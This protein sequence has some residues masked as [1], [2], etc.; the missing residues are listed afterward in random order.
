[1][2]ALDAHQPQARLPGA[3][4]R[5]EEPLLDR[6]R[7]RLAARRHYRALGGREDADVDL[8]AHRPAIRASRASFAAQGVQRVKEGPTSAPQSQRFAGRSIRG[9][10]VRVSGRPLPLSNRKRVQQPRQLRTEPVLRSPVS[11]PVL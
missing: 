4:Q 7:L 3:V 8:G 11:E 9:S 6:L 5:F 2:P 10:W 1:V